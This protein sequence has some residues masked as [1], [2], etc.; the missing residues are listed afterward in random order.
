MLKE[1]M[2]FK[3]CSQLL[4]NQVKILIL[5]QKCNLIYWFSIFRVNDEMKPKI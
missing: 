3:V 5:N 4:D 2:K 1:I